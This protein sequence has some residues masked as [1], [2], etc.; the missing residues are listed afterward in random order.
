VKLRVADVSVVAETLRVE[1]VPGGVAGG[2]VTVKEAVPFCPPLLAVIVTG[3]PATTA[4]TSPVPD[5][6]A[7]AGLLDV[8]VTVRPVRMLFDASRTV[9]VNCVPPAPA[10]AEALAGL[11][12]TVATGVSVVV[13]LATLERA[14][15]T[16]F[17]FSVPRNA[18]AWN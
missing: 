14:P 5:T 13:P 11:T 15:N 4:E 17:T 6:V 18:I 1:T 7:I 9:A 16:A 8:Q 10:F 3:P 2:A 12:V